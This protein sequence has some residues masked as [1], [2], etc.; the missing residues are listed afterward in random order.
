MSVLQNVDDTVLDASIGHVF[1]TVETWHH[2]VGGDRV[3]GD[4]S[5]QLLS[6]F[7]LLLLSAAVTTFLCFLTGNLFFL[8]YIVIIDIPCRWRFLNLLRMWVLI[9][10]ESDLE[11]HGVDTVSD[12]V[13]DS[14]LIVSC[15]E[16]LIDAG[17]LIQPTFPH[18]LTRLPDV[19]DVRQTSLWTYVWTVVDIH[20][21]ILR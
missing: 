4:W 2:V 19:I 11:E 6:F 15:P 5:Q 18:P 1:H 9:T 14:H 21:K 16:T 12:V 20:S 8:L 3:N 17:I 13:R 10:K 7:P